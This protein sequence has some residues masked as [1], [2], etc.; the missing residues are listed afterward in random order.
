MLSNFEICSVTIHWVDEKFIRKDFVLAAFPVD[1]FRHSGEF[2]AEKIS[3]CLFEHGISIDKM[4][5]CV[6]DDAPN[7]QSA[8]NCLEK[9]RLHKNL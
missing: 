9:D 2:L 4:I 1:G 5:C 7:M 6:R 8:C 3:D